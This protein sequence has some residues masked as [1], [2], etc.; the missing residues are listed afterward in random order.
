MSEPATILIVDDI[1]ANREILRELLERQAYRLVEAADGPTALRLAAETQ[2][3]LVLLDVMMP[4]MDGF[5]VCRRLRADPGLAEVP[6]MMVT[7]LDD[8]ASRLAGI[9]AGADDFITK[10]YNL[11]ELR[12]RVSTTTRLNRYRRLHETQSALLASEARLLQMAERSADVFWFASP[13]PMR[14]TFVSPAVEKIWGRPAAQFY[15]DARLWESAIHPDD[16][17]RVHAAYAALLAGRTAPFAEEFRVVRP[18]GTVRWVINRATPVHDAAGVIVSL[19]GVAC[20]ITERKAAEHKLRE[21]NDILTNSHEGMLIVNLADGISLWN[22]GAE[23]I[24]GWTTAE[25]LGGRVERLLGLDDPGVGPVLRAAIERDGFWGGELRSRTR[26]NR[27]IFLDY[28]TTLVRDET[29]QPRARLS[30]FSDITEKKLL[31][32]QFLHTQRLDCIGMLAAGIAH[33]LNNVLAPVLFAAQLLRG[34]LSAPRDLQILDV[35]E[36]N[37]RRGTALVKQILGFAHTG[38]GEHRPTQVK[39]L[40]RDITDLIESTFPKS[41]ELQHEIPA[42]LW[43]VQGN[44]TQI[45]QVL[46][47]LSVNARDAM[48]QGGRLRL[49]AANRR[50]DAAEAA[51]IPGAQPG[52]WLVLEVADTGTGIAPE[53]A[54]HIWEPFFTTKDAGKG[55][56]LGLSTVRGIVTSHHGFVT[57][58]TAVGRG[59]SFRV[60][61]PATEGAPPR[62]VTTAPFAVPEGEGELV[63]LVDDEASIRDFASALLS[64]HG[65]RV[66]SCPDGM[67]AINLI[68]AHAEAIS[69]VVTDVDMPCLGG[70]ELVHALLK[71]RPG[72]RLIAMSGLAKDESGGSVV[73]EI[74]QLVH[75]FLPKPFTQEDL[76]TAMHLVLHPA[77]SSTPAVVC[78]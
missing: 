52:S 3:D 6:V 40:L 49:T 35:L 17:P 60:F 51:T 57:V 64:Q 12:A 44:P 23:K 36:Q 76:L 46:L 62:T 43:L 72:I 11:A 22:H 69:V 1:A 37:A 54:K 18:D 48:P 55:T 10:P 31:Q 9:E 28:R 29:G 14:L 77:G 47:N 8:Q 66:L 19:G 78:S 20:D 53:V 63:L 2:P 58:D 61:L 30:F 45:H 21:Q 32:E 13:H 65:Y 50:I 25:A 34:N 41:I 70:V 42:D 71:I 59:T 16:Q 38:L 56:G 5:A 74:Q 33:D 67:A 15:E 7:A 73:S 24:L 26:D 68:Q 39:H 75:A 27:K 4:G